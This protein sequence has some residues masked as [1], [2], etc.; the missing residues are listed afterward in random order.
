M[1]FNMKKYIITLFIL[2]IAVLSASESKIPNITILDNPHK[3]VS[4][5]EG[6]KNKESAEINIKVKKRNIEEIEGFESSDG[7]EF[8]LPDGTLSV[9]EEIK[10]VKSLA[11]LPNESPKNKRS[12]RSLFS[13]E[14]PST[15]TDLEGKKIVKIAKEEVEKTNYIIKID[16]NSNKIN[17]IYKGRVRRSNNIS[18]RSSQWM[19]SRSIPADGGTYL[20]YDESYQGIYDGMDWLNVASSYYPVDEQALDEY[21]VMTN[22]RMSFSKY[23]IRFKYF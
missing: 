12:K 3:E 4:T 22:S 18:T 15:I 14:T 20:L 10:V 23:G 8:T 2:V 13:M 5:I 17:K 7:I 6:I 11:N 9:E 1:K 21:N 19:T 16:K